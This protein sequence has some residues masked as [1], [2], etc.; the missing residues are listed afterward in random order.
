LKR[1]TGRGDINRKIPPPKCDGIAC[2]DFRMQRPAETPAPRRLR[3]AIGNG[4]VIMFPSRAH[5][6]RLALVLVMLGLATL[7]SP[8]PASEDQGSLPPASGPV[9]LT[10]TGSIAATNAPGRAEFDR[11]MLEALGVES[12]TTSS[13]WTDGVQRFEGVRASKVLEAVGARGSAVR[14]TAVNE[15]VAEI[16]VE[17]IQDFPVLLALRQNGA[18]LTARDKGPIWIVFPRDD[19]PSLDDPRIDLQWVWQLKAIDVR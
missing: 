7:G 11:A 14:A 16:P 12:L 15:Y 1:E 19:Y 3:P 9:I 8:S 5:G 18:V 6:A 17:T 2:R 13:S 4:E 10:V